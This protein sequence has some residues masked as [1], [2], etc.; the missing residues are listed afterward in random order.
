MMQWVKAQGSK[1]LVGLGVI[2]NIN[3]FFKDLWS[4]QFLGQ[5][6]PMPTPLLKETLKHIHKDKSY[7]NVPNNKEFHYMHNINNIQL[8][9]NKDPISLALDITK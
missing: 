2:N 3:N 6:Q 4:Q 1:T 5:S 7:I 8:H 9:V